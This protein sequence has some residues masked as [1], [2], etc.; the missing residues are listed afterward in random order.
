MTAER[1]D[2]LNGQDKYNFNSPVEITPEEA[3]EGWH[4]CYEFDGLLVK[5]D[6]N[7]EYCGQSCIDWDGSL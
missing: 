2:E 7:E 4:F 1:Y 6:P 3:S 5:G